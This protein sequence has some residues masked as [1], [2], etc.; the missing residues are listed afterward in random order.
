MTRTL[1]GTR[2]RQLRHAAGYTVDQAAEKIGRS[3]HT[4]RSYESGRVS[5]PAH[6]LGEIAAVYDCQVS[7]FYAAD[8]SQDADERLAAIKAAA[9]N[10]PPLAP[11]DLGVIVSLLAAAVAP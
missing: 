5:P 1:S 4:I 11:E 2:L 3:T 10:A 8:G 9:R 7:D 6:V